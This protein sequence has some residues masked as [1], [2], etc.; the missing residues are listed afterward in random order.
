[1]SSECS[2]DLTKC[3]VTPEEF[4][5]HLSKAHIYATAIRSSY[6]NPVIEAQM[7]GAAVMSVPNTAKEELYNPRYS[8]ISNNPDS[9]VTRMKNFFGDFRYPSSTVPVLILYFRCNFD[10]PTPVIT[11]LSLKFSLARVRAEKIHNWT[12]ARHAP[13]VAACAYIRSLTVMPKRKSGKR[14]WAQNQ[15]LQKS[16][17]YRQYIHCYNKKY[18]KTRLF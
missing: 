11:V 10:R 3:K 18:F 14:R 12:L 8:I 1:M 17:L 5:L 4:Q 13:N 2:F 16:E 6:E 7:A 15:F 9:L